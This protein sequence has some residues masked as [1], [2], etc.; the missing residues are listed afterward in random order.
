[1]NRDAS[2]M[3]ALFT[4]DDARSLL[5]K[6]LFGLER[7]AQRVTQSGDLAMTP[8]P[9]VFGSKAE[10]P[11]ITTDFAES[12]I[13]MI[14]SPCTS[15]EEAYRE[16]RAYHEMVEG[17]IGD[18]FLWPIS[19]PPRLPE[20]NDIPI[21]R[22]S[23]TASGTNANIYRNGLAL[24]YGKKMQMISGIHFNYSFDEDLIDILHTRFGD[25]QTRRDFMD[26]LYFS[27][28]RNFLRYRWLLIYLFGASPHC[29]PTYYSVV[30]KEIKMVQK[31]CP[32]R[33]DL[34]FRNVSQHATSLRVSR[35]GYDN[36]NRKNQ[37]IHYN[38]MSEYAR[39]LHEL[40]STR[41]P[42]YAKLGMYRNGSQVQLSENVLQK[43]SEYYSSIRLK[44]TVSSGE[45]QLNALLSRGVKYL[46]VRI[47]DCNP[48][49]KMGISVEQMHF[50]HVFLLYCLF[51]KSPRITE[52]EH[53]R[54]NENHQLVALM[55]RDEPLILSRAKEDIS[56]EAWGG[57]IMDGLHEIAGLMDSDTGSESESYRMV[58]ERQREKLTD[59]SLLPSEIMHKEMTRLHMNYLEYGNH[60]AKEHHTE[61]EGGGK[62]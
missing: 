25:G 44:Q 18:E 31:C 38:S 58:V 21:A 52:A 27:V 54:L 51:T 30:K 9:A 57:E 17:G 2:D 36:P 40:M 26:D 24:R 23:E 34:F 41:S 59:R 56:L 35:F 60:L 16:L 45:C 55:G 61:N 53:R 7:E 10:N 20:E 37:K 47:L 62:P 12:Q 11:H 3:M 49:D 8:H 43:E 15:P 33:Y 29:D 1:M 42:Q 6:G 28:A 5:K 46:E 39:K 50:M 48:Y 4:N 22:F 14:T 13:E 32:T 19:M